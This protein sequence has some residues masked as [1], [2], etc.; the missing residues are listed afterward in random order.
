MGRVARM[1]A[2]SLDE[3]LRVL[4]GIRT[5]RSIVYESAQGISLADLKAT[6]EGARGDLAGSVRSAPDAAFEK[7]SPD[8]DGNEVWSVGE[9]LSHCN[10]A[11]F[12]LGSR[13]LRLLDIDAGQPPPR[14]QRWSDIQMLSRAEAEQALDAVDIDAL[15]AMVPSDADLDVTGIDEFFGTMSARSILYLVAVHEADHVRQVWKLG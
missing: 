9:I 6:V 11:M 14:W 4:D 2:S 15:F 13:A 8:S 10:A 5:N 12:D 3:L 1:A 7:Q